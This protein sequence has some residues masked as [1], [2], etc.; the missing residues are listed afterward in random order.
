MDWPVVSPP[1]PDA[2]LPLT[3]LYYRTT[4]DSPR[5]PMIVWGTEVDVT[6]QRRIADKLESQQT[7]AV[8]ETPKD[9]P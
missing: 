7:A 9:Q 5:D 2:A 3:Q 4:C 1:I 6:E 8:A